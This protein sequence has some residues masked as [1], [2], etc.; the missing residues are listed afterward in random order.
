MKNQLTQ[1]YIDTAK[2]K[3]LTDS[4]AIA[5]I[6]DMYNQYGQYSSLINDYIIPQALA[7]GGTLD[8]VYQA[9]KNNT[10]KY[11]TRRESVYN[12]L[13][14]S[15][16]SGLSSYDV[17]TPWVEGDQVA[18]IHDKEMIVPAESNPLNPANATSSY[19]IPESSEDNSEVVDTLKW[20][21]TRLEAKLDKL[22]QASSQTNLRRTYS[23]TRDLDRAFSLSK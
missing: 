22:I 2:S 9:T 5:Y 16:L 1:S 3:G 23:D 19:D 18:L 6:A 13:L 15:D 21:V 20:M 8:A 7:A 10:S 4:K 17:G 11:L 12:S 14:S